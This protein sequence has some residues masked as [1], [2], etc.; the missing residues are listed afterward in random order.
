MTIT[1]AL[2]KISRGVYLLGWKKEGRTGMVA[3]AS[4]T[5]HPSR[6]LPARLSGSTYVL[7]QKREF[8]PQPCAK[9]R[10]LI[11]VLLSA[12]LGSKY[13]LAGVRKGA[14]RYTCCQKVLSHPSGAVCLAKWIQQS[15]HKK[16]DGTD[17]V[18]GGGRL[19]RLA[20]VQYM[21]TRFMNVHVRIMGHLHVTIRHLHRHP[22][23]WR[24]FHNVPPSYQY[25]FDQ[26]VLE[27]IFLVSRGS[28]L[29][30][31]LLCG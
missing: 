24:P 29:R 12:W 21:T 13:L 10:C 16:G 27:C 19:I 5:P 3:E 9:N 7:G 11:L 4:S 22:L 28:S 20:L 17:H 25:P 15:N 2:I 23:G 6:E 26:P 18:A 1:R 8:V 30:C 14:G 31:R